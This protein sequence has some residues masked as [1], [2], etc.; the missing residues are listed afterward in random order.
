MNVNQYQKECARTEC[1]QGEAMVRMV[2]MDPGDG[3]PRLIPNDTPYLKPVRINHAAMGIVKEGGEILAELEKWL[4]YGRNP[5]FAKMQEELGDVLWYCAQLCNA[6][7]VN[8]DSVMR[9]NLAK[10]K[11]RYP[12]AYSQGGAPNRNDQ[13]VVIDTDNHGFGHVGESEF[14]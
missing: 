1:P 14:K 7:G 11:H 4:Y 6:L 10:L 2:N 12:E 9:R 13:E 3:S 5:N 8:L